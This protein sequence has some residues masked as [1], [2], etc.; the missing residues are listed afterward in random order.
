MDKVVLL[1]PALLEGEEVVAVAAL[2]VRLA[3]VASL[4]KPRLI[5]SGTFS[6]R[7]EL[8]K[9]LLTLLISTPILVG[10][11]LYYPLITHLVKMTKLGMILA[12][13]AKMA[14]NY[15]VYVTPPVEM[16]VG[17]LLLGRGHRG[18][19]LRT[20]FRLQAFTLSPS[21]H[22]FRREVRKLQTKLEF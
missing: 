1:L 12:N 10:I 19:P 20:L 14:R 16:V 11:N 13:L 9:R 15:L 6:A 17:K 8:G 18:H 22:T 7:F 21:R 4:M 3:P 5:I 2:A